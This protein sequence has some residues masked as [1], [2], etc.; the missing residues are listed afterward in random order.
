[1]DSK[2]YDNVKNMTLMFFLDRL[3][4]K[5]QP[6]TLHDLSCQFG[7]KGFTK[8]MRQIAGGSQSGLRKF[9]LQYPSLF[10]IE[11]DHVRVT[12]L[13]SEDPSSGVG[14]KRDYA[15]E[16]VEYFENKLGMYGNAEVPI[17]SLL[18]H[19]SQASPEIRHISG[20]H[21]KEFKD[22]LQ[23]YPDVFVIQDEY[24]VL[25]SVLQTPD[26]KLNTN[27][28]K[29]PEEEPLDPQLTNQL[30]TIFEGVVK[31]EGKVSV[32]QLLNNLS[33]NYPRLMWSK[34]M[35][36]TQDLIA[37]LKMN[38]HIFCVQS[39]M[40]SLVPQRLQ[41]Y[42]TSKVNDNNNTT[43]TMSSLPV[44][45]T[46]GICRSSENSKNFQQRL[47]M[48]VM[49]AVADNSAIDYKD[50]N[51][52]SSSNSG[53]IGGKDCADD[54]LV[55]MMKNTKMI[56]KV[57]EGLT[58]VQQILS[59]GQEAVAV[60]VEGVNLGP[61]GPLTLV[62]LGTMDKK[63]YIF[64]LLSSP[65]L[66]VEGGLKELLQSENIFKVVHD[67]RNDSGAFYHQFGVIM[68]NV[69][70]MQAAHAVLQQQDAGKPVY[71][72][73]NISLNTLCSTYGGPINPRKDQMKNLY[74]RDQKFWIRR[75]LTEDMIFHAAFD[76]FC[77]L[78]TV[79][80]TIREMLRPESLPLLEELCEEQVLVYIRPD[81]VKGRKK[82]RKI[83]MEVSDLKRKLATPSCKQIV[84]SNREIRLLRYVEL[85]DEERNKIEGSQKVAKKLERLRNRGTS[86]DSGSIHSGSGYAGDDCSDD[87]SGEDNYDDVE[88]GEERDD[89]ECSIGYDTFFDSLSMNTS[90]S[91]SL[92]NYRIYSPDV[93]LTNDYID[94]ISIN[95]PPGG[96]NNCNCN[97][98]LTNTL[99][100]KEKNL[101]NVRD[102]GSQTLSTGD[103]VITKVFFEEKLKD[104]FQEIK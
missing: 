28:T 67:C 75:P 93:L 80:N 104:K 57:K 103:I 50:H 61:S 23:R 35:K 38:S 22:F 82:Q 19:R 3:M 17:K 64:D 34:M 55:Q 100:R 39:N 25:K 41:T 79:Y 95:W 14:T 7:T 101:T 37:F 48:Q 86:N 24:V 60:D 16:A 43:N 70:D 49:K 88:E 71:K 94:G 65:Q 45:P 74:R 13:S 76:V 73:K 21:V 96:V 99:K 69:F 59:S 58:V 53:L 12:C 51:N 54:S 42:I 87:A 4:D 56:T 20:Q 31:A 18:G 46:N 52:L 62:Q 47:R 26:G 97:C 6:R 10:T 78:P 29:V 32:E 11:G 90:P 33:S 81:E 40:V 89:S 44:S 83:D 9:L 30:L 8:E 36:S 102:S 66:M 92:H 15:L 91:H 68:K 27:I 5:G 85:T 2:D 72:V 1:M 63:V 84:L 77:L 98:L